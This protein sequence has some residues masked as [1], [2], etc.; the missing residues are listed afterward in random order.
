MFSFYLIILK[1]GPTSAVQARPVPTS[2]PDE[3]GG[4]VPR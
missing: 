4:W 1:I 3:D 2:P